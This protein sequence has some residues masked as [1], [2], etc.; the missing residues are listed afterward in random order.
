MSS[1]PTKAA[2]QHGLIS[3]STAAHT[4]NIS[5]DVLQKYTGRGLL[6]THRFYPDSEHPRRY[7]IGYK[8]E[9]INNIKTKMKS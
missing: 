1:Y 7:H 6:P 8:T 3:P 9:D 5:L 4:L 2:Q